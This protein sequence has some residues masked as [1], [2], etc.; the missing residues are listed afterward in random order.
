M[1]PPPVDRQG[2]KWKNR[3]TKPQSKFPDPEWFL[4]KGTAGKNQNKT[5]R[6]VFQ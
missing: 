2:L 1:T 5:E 4:S 6:K 3:V